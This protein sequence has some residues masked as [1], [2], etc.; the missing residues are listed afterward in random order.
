MKTLIVV[1]SP[2]KARKL[3]EYLGKDYIVLASGG[4]ICDLAKGGQYGIGVDV[5]NDFKPHYMLMKEKVGLLNEIIEAA[6]MAD[7]ILLGTDHDREGEAIA[8]HLQRYLSSVNK[9]T[10]RISF[11]E[12]TK[13]AI[14]K[15]IENAHDIDMNIV[16]SQE[17]RRSLDRI[18]GFLVSPMLHSFYGSNN[19]S[20]GRVQSVAT[21]L[22]IDREQE[23]SSFIPDEFWNIAAKFITPTNETFIAKFNTKPKNK[24]DADVVVASIKNQPEFYVAKIISQEK[25]EKPCPPLITASLQQYMAKKHSFEPDRTMKAAQ[26]LYENGFCTYIR[27][28]S[29][30]SSKEA[31]SSVREWIKEKYE[32]PTKPNAYAAKGSSQDA[33]EAIR[34][35][36]I[37]NI[38]EGSILAGDEKDVYTAI[39]KHFVA[40][41]MCPA[42]WDTMQVNICSKTD[43]KIL[44]NVS[45]KALKHN[46]YL[47]IFGDID[48]GKI[49]IPNL[50]EKDILKLAAD[51]KAEQKFTQPAARYNDASIIKELE[52]KQ[53]GRPAT[54][55]EII[56]KITARNYV[57]KQGNTYR[58]TE[59]G[60]KI[61]TTLISL[62]PFMEFDYSAMLEKKL[63]D[64]EHGELEQLAMLKEFF[65]PFKQQLNKAYISNG[66]TLCEKCS[67]PMITR[68]VKTNGNTFLGCSNW[69]RCKNTKSTEVAAA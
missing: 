40:S 1:E 23:I 49:D 48:P 16:K 52:T 41:Q 67:G 25:K 3:T 68:T 42:I 39:W 12:I 44:F 7:I 31:I 36:N 6:S 22:I 54:Y 14:I 2:N 19:L 61:T 9:P 53:I 20:A 10:K 29:I 58:P 8:Y 24:A 37:N 13:S 66:N 46:G 56:K 5:D 60:K 69:P 15:A 47:E 21:R 38:P 11:G 45:G 59:L 34:P 27:T 65:G 51:A 63:D 26:N 30:R 18:V 33:H 43:P 4:H 62:F 64:I 50:H 17:A 55:A 57:E 35:T 32:L 28:D